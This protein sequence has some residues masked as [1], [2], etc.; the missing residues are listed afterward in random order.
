MSS[1]IIDDFNSDCSHTKRKKLWDIAS[2]AAPRY[3]RCCA[4]NTAIIL[5]MHDTHDGHD[6]I[7]YLLPTSA[8]VSKHIKII[9]NLPVKIKRKISFIGNSHG[10]TFYYLEISKFIFCSFC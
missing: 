4:L 10:S 5:H 2:C 9:E 6:A 1:K 3:T 7:T 8:V